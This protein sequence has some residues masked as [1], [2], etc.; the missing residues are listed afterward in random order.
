MQILLNK[1]DITKS[2]CEAIVN[3]ANEQLQAGGGVCGAIFKAAGVSD[4]QAACDAI[5]GCKTGYAVI[6]PGFKLKAKYVVHTVGPIYRDESSAKYLAMA[7]YNTLKE[8]NKNSIK[9]VAFP[10]I[11]T[12]IYGYP[13]KEAADIA[14]KAIKDFERDY[15][16]TSINSIE[17]CFIDDETYKYFVE[18]Y[19]RNFPDVFKIVFAETVNITGSIDYAARPFFIQ[20]LNHEI[21]KY[22]MENRLLLM[23]IGVYFNTEEAFKGFIEMLDKNVEQKVLKDEY[24]I[25]FRRNDSGKRR[26][27]NFWEEK[28]SWNDWG[29]DEMDPIL[30]YLYFGKPPYYIGP[31]TGGY[32]FGPEFIT[33]EYYDANY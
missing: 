20:Y 10:S 1:K 8:C 21:N 11:S 9:S 24:L 3:A 18:G 28:A 17:F 33:K 6:T 16:N 19:I 13:I 23:G 5:G 22:Q 29:C 4:L 27:H 15:P 14:F 31:L 7:Y 25:D 30:D 26:L 2:G 32:I 12:G